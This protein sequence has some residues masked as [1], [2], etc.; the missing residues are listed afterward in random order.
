M[1]NELDV[2][3]TD[4]LQTARRVRTVFLH[5]L[6]LMTGCVRSTTIEGKSPS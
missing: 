2:I 6:V 4:R 1:S 3:L 5:L